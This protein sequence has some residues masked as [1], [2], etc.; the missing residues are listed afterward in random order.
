MELVGKILSL[1]GAV[2]LT[3]TMVWNMNRKIPRM[4]FEPYIS[5][6]GFGLYI[7]L[8]TSLL[9]SIFLLVF[10]FDFFRSNP[11]VNP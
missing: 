2:F 7:P 1:T 4:P 6:F 10:V 3:A 8:F 9:I 5:K 11:I